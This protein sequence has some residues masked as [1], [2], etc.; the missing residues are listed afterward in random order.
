MQFNLGVRYRQ[1]EMTEQAIVAYEKAV[2]L[3]PGYADAWYDLGLM[4]KDDKQFEKSI[5]AFNKYLETEKGK[6]D[7]EAQQRAKDEIEKLGGKPTG[8]AKKPGKP[9][10]KKK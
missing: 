10:P 6:Q 4:Y 1:H 5:S 9:A 3:D 2:G 7:P 8:A